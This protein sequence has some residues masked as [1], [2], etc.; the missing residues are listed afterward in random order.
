MLLS[1]LVKSTGEWLASSWPR[2]AGWGSLAVFLPTAGWPPAVGGL[3]EWVKVQQ[4]RSVAPVWAAV[5]IEGS[6]LAGGPGPALLQGICT[7]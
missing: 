2:L 3:G 5:V 1:P 7:Y 6:D 4:A